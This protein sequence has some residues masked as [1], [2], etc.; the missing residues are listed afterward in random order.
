MPLL[1]AEEQLTS[2]LVLPVL[3]SRI[4]QSS[5]HVTIAGFN[6]G[7]VRFY[8]ETGQLL[9]EKAFHDSPVKRIGVQAMPEGK[10]FTQVLHSQA[11][12]ELAI[13]YAS[14]V[15]TVSA[16]DLFSTL[17]CSLSS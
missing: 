13:V 8:T 10:H 6:S 5:W 15:A 9:L 11:V 3:S 2:I 1:K 7:Y 14:M 17:A 16:G 12:Q 4:T